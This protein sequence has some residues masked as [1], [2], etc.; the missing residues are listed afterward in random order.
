M[1]TRRA[2]PSPSVSS[3][4]RNP[5]LVHIYPTGPG[6]GCRHPLGTSPLVIGRNNEC[7]IC[8]NDSSVSRRHVCI[9][10]RP[11]G[12]YAVDLQS[13]NGTFV[14][15]QPAP[16][17]KREDGDYL[18]VGNCIYR[19]LSGGN[20]EADYHEEIYRLTII[21]A[22]TEIHNKR[23]LLEFLDRELVRSARHSRQL[24][25]VMFDVDRF[26]V[27]NDEFGHL[28]GDLTLRELAACVKKE[29]RQDE[30]F[31]RYGGEE[32]AIVLPET[33]LEHARAAAERIRRLVEAQPFH[34]GG[35]S[36]KVTISLG[37]SV[38]SGTDVSR[39]AD[40]IR[41][42]DEKLYQAKRDGRN[43]VVA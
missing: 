31:A 8:I 19:F 38:T 6:M 13:M 43:R 25:L 29:V 22:L 7:E 14:N 33:D 16:E 11:D 37:V 40:L 32:F 34:F 39:A 17:R 2:T 12:Y 9:E 42:A 28:G 24:A 15:N 10:Y 1:E 5:C 21:D 30:L 18:R 27:I 4:N 26:K 20:V 41:Q 23:Y 3:A 35:K 36:Y